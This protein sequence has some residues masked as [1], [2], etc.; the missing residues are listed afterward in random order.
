MICRLIAPGVTGIAGGY[1]NR[2]VVSGARH[3][4]REHSN[5]YVQECRVYAGYQ[6]ITCMLR[7]GITYKYVRIHIFIHGTRCVVLAVVVEKMVKKSRK[8]GTKKK[9]E[10]PQES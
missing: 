8:Q 10:N 7:T 2:L 4:I 5:I 3:D 6:S 1:D 9:H